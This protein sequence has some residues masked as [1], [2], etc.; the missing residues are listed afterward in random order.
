MSPLPM[1]ILDF[2]CADEEIK[3]IAQNIVGVV[4]ND[5]SPYRAF[6]MVP[7]KVL[8]KPPFPLK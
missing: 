6:S 2:E 7:L 8:F 1:A 4:Q 3:E 5:L